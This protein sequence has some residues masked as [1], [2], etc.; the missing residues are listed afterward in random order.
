MT[1][2][3]VFASVF[4]ARQAILAG[5]VLAAAV[6]CTGAFARVGP[7]KRLVVKL[8]PGTNG[9]TQGKRIPLSLVDATPFTLNIEALDRN[10]ARDAGMNGFVRFSV[11]PG[12][13]TSIGHPRAAGRSVRLEA[14]LAENVVVSVVG[15]YG[16]SAIWVEDAGYAPADPLGP[17]PPQCSDR[18]DNDGDG[19]VDSVADEGCEAAN[20]DTEAGGSFASGASDILYFAYPRVAD[21]RGV[22]TGGGSTPFRKQQIRVD[23]GHRSDTN[24]YEWSTVVTRISADGFYVTDLGDARGFSSIFS[25]NFNPPPAMRVCDRLKSF[26]GTITEFFGM[27]QVGYPT[28]T[29][30]EWDPAKRPCMVPEPTLLTPTTSDATSLRKVV[31]GLVRVATQDNLE[32]RITKHFGPKKPAPPPEGQP[33]SAGYD[34]ADDASNCDL[35]ED[36]RVDFNNDP[37]KT[38]AAKCTAD[39][40]CTEYSNYD[41]RSAFRFVIVD[42]T[43]GDVANVQGNGTTAAGFDPLLLKGKPLRSFSGTLKFFSGGTQFTIEARCS[44]DIV[45]PL[46]KSPLPS[47]KACVYAR[48][49]ID[50]NSGSN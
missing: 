40:E 31:A 23:T 48:T 4:G 7:A 26:G 34:P 46:D 29:L 28:W 38:C 11:K 17:T 44:D 18:V 27:T 42:K 35:N 12:A 19:R 1:A 5:V 25:F 15:A 33:A 24:E 37:E 2:R 3:G 36:G 50:N 13:V 47:D 22:E 9:G 6:G 20:D 16:D 45:V 39:A 21:V 8:A 41:S 30:E 32:V 43:T 14:G 10:G 49:I